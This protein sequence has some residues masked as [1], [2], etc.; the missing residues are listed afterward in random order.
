MGPN[1]IVLHS[2]HIK[3]KDRN[4]LIGH[5]SALLWF[6]GLPSSGKSTIA[7]EVEKIL[8]K[9]KVLAYVLDGDNIRH[10]LNSDLGF[11]KKDRQENIR[12]IAEV[13]KLFMD[14]GLIILTAFVSPYRADR[15]MVREMFKGDNFFEVYVKCSIEECIKR[16]PKG[17]YKMALN[18]T[19]K[20]YTGIS[21]PYEEPLNPEIVLNTETMSIDESVNKVIE[22][23][24]EKEIV[25]KISNN[26]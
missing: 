8:F 14:A 10:G 20:N 2:G 17:F 11:S 5:K 7:H 15:E 1:N 3:R 16:D 23:L 13:S 21:S 24:K 4:I 18:G 6:T 9:N 22:F 12:R 26:V 19:I 25:A